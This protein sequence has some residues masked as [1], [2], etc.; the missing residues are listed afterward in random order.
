MLSFATEM[1]QLVPFALLPSYKIYRTVV[2]NINALLQAKCLIFLSDSNQIWSVSIDFRNSPQKHISKT[3]SPVSPVLIH[4]D[5]RTER[6]RETDRQTDR[7]YEADTLIPRLMQT[8][9][10]W[11]TSPTTVNI[12][13]GSHGAW[14]TRVNHTGVLTRVA[15]TLG[16]KREQFTRT[17]G[18]STIVTMD[19][20]VA[21]GCAVVCS[22]FYVSLAHNI[23]ISGLLLSDSMNFSNF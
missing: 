7:H 12:R 21:E 1:Q 23:P 2:N 6:E 14:I 4:A 11:N 19:G 8:R 10:T 13:P 3:K 5:G 15:S 17:K 18:F 9:P 16:G 20:T 22:V